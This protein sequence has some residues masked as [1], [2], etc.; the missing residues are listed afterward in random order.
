M[1]VVQQINDPETL[2]I[3]LSGKQILALFLGVF[4]LGGYF[5]SLHFQVTS[6]RKAFEERAP[7]IAQIPEIKATVDTIPELR[8]EVQRIR[9]R[10]PANG[11]VRVTP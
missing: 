7:L 5:T 6:M 3:K 1:S 2:R 8:A 11:S 4:A 9:D 10:L